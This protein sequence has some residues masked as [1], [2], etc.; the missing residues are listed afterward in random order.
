MCKLP[1][2]T[3]EFIIYFEINFLNEFYQVALKIG[4]KYIV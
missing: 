4:T 2:N 1:N 3:F